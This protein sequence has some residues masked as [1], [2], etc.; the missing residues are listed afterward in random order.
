MSSPDDRRYLD[1]HEWLRHE[2][3]VVTIG[4]T[5][6]AVDELTDITYIEITKTQ[7]RVNAGDVFG[8][9]ESVKTTSDLYVGIDGTVTD[10]NQEAIDNP[11][12]LN[13]D[14]LNRGWLIKMTPSDPRQL[15]SLMT[16]QDYDA[17][18]GA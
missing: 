8:E 1:T 7:G 5:R 10:V 6:F 18:Y 3:G 13:E 11:A 12:I 4:L 14:P 2:D 17:K 16:A 9:I 15:E